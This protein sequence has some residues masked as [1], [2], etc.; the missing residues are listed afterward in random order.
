MNKEERLHQLASAIF[1]KKI[2][3]G[4]TNDTNR[5]YHESLAKNAIHTAELFY[6]EYY[7]EESSNP[8]PDEL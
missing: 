4:Y 2:L 3:P 5:D 8:P 6:K 1:L 7:K